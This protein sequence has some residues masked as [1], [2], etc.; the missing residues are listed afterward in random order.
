MEPLQRIGNAGRDLGQED[1]EFGFGH[2]E[3][4]VS[5]RYPDNWRD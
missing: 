1:H 4:E 5:L 2:M 3:S